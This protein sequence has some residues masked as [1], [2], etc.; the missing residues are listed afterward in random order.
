MVKHLPRM[1]MKDILIFIIISIFLIS[2]Y[3]YNKKIKLC[4]KPLLQFLSTQNDNSDD[5]SLIKLKAEAAS[6]FRLFRQFIY[7]S[8]GAAGGIGTFTAI[9]QLILSFQNDGD[10]S[11]AIQ[12]I[13]IDVGAVISAVI[14]WNIESTNEKKKIENFKDKQRL[15]DN[16][17]SNDDITERELD[18]SKLPVEIQVSENNENITRIVSLSELQSKGKQHVIIVTGST[19][20]VKDSVISARLEGTE[21][22]NSKDTIIIPFIT[23]DN[24]LERA[25]K[26]GFGAN[27][28]ESLMSSPYIGKPKQVKLYSSNYY[29]LFHNYFINTKVYRHY[30]LNSSILYLKLNV[31]EAI[32]EKEF[33]LAKSQGSKDVVK[34]GLV[35]AIKKTGKVIRRGLGLPPWKILLEELN[36]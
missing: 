35:L 15:M 36:K 5:I 28:R 16:R 29:F 3:K 22:F 6:P 13:I 33:D 2:S 27:R 4:R 18:L 1:P 9:P 34:Q 30:L 21:L 17:L 26:K 8:I 31:W 12:N 24:Q 7:G 23:D 19:N 20:F 25:T 11:T 32:L 10:K 14:F